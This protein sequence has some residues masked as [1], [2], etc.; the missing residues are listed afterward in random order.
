MEKKRGNF[1]RKATLQAMDFK[2]LFQVTDRGKGLKY[3][4]NESMAGHT[5]K[6]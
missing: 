5:I 3:D 4:E 6:L 2:Q 1:V